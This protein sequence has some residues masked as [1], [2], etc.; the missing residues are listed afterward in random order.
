MGVLSCG[1]SSP[2]FFGENVCFLIKNNLKQTLFVH[3]IMTS[4]WESQG[5][6]PIGM[7]HPGSRIHAGT[8][9]SPSP[10]EIVPVVISQAAAR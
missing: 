1:F 8:C 5:G 7:S 9:L 6:T 2:T 4:S 3:C 10:T